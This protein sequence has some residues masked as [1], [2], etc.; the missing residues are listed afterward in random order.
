MIRL[1]FAL[2]FLALSAVQTGAQGGA[3]PEAPLQAPAAR[4]AVR[5]ESDGAPLAGAQVNG[6]GGG[7]VTNAAG[8][9]RLRLPAGPTRLQVRRLGFA[10][11]SL[12]LVLP[13]GADTLVRVELH[14]VAE[15]MTSVVVSSQRGATRIED[16][17][18]RIEALAGEDVAEKMEM[19]PADATGFLAEMSGVRVQRTAAATGAAGVRLQ[20]LRPRYTLMLVDGLPL[21]GAPGSGLDLLQL[22]PA[23]LR[24]VE[25]VKGPATALYGPSALGGMI[26]LVTKRPGSE[27]D[28]LVSQST[29]GG[30]HAYG[31]YSE[32]W[33]PR[34]GMTALAGVHRQGERDRDGDRWAEMPGVRRVEL[35]PRLFYDGRAGTGA[36]LTAGLTRE[37]RTGGFLAG[38]LAPDGTVYREAHGTTRA[39]LGGIGHVLR[40]GTL[41]Q[42]RAAATH[43]VQSHDRTGNPEHVARATGFA[44]LSASRQ[45]GRHDALGGVAL[46]TDRLAV[47]EA[48]GLDHAWTTAAVFAQ[49]QWDATDRLAVT[50]SG[51]VDR[52]GTHGTLASP[53][54]SAL[55]R[56]RDGLTA[57]A[58]W[59]TGAGVPSPYVEEAAPVGIRRVRGFDTV[60]P[61]RARYLSADLTGTA[62]PVELNVT[63]FDTRIRDAVQAEANGSAIDVRNAVGPV[64]SRGLELFAEVSADDLYLT[65]LYGYTDAREP[66]YGTTTGAAAPY[67]PRHTGG[68]DLTWE[69]DE[70]GT[71]IAL[72]GFYSGPQRTRDDPFVDR[73]PAYTVVGLLLA[74]QVGPWRLFASLENLT[75]VRQT[76]AARMVLPARRPD[77]RWTTAP[78]GQL[79]GR[80][81]SVGMRWSR[82]GM[83]H[84][85]GQER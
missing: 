70:T 56:L 24:Q 17:P 27:R 85:L 33:S 31:W 61:E 2:P 5:V 10:A 71:W 66:G 42:W 37:D 44:E 18:L 23:D 62:G 47:R 7:G 13:T 38:A 39:D 49:D 69:R 41:W 29:Q 55:Y 77:G 74:Q 84:G 79:E 1:C 26:N 21:P 4:L 34:W 76:T 57:R 63:V 32:Q 22:P 68:L 25:V 64:T 67:L 72:E 43:D 46:N 14:P 58:S 15:S 28:L 16:A 48:T 54:L 80:V 12:A 51:R 52:H 40:G 50:A 59:A 60:R 82:Q 45:V 6:A 35:R 75:D 3:R 53:R 78:W 11:E 9:V 8:L 81:I 36:L 19:R 20:G 65:A 30:T 83:P 73:T